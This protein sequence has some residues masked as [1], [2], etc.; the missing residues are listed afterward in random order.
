MSELKFKA[1][2]S[3]ELKDD[4]EAALQKVAN[5]F[6]EDV[7]FSLAERIVS[8]SKLTKE[9][10]FELQLSKSKEL[11]KALLEALASK[12]KLTEKDASALGRKVDGG[13]SKELEEK[14]LI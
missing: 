14:G 13:I 1:G 10:A 8:K 2:I 7:E 4:F 3:P 6:I 5:E 9:Q 11:Q 12:S